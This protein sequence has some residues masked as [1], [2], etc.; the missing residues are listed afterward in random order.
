[1]TRLENSS[2]HPYAG[3]ECGYCGG[4]IRSEDRARDG[5]PAGRSSFEAGAWERNRSSHLRLIGSHQFSCSRSIEN[6]NRTWYIR[7]IYMGLHVYSTYIRMFAWKLC[8]HA[9]VHA[10]GLVDCVLHLRMCVLNE[11]LDRPY[12]HAC[13]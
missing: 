5:V 6:R 8:T 9:H 4:R 12:C 7:S 11:F 1:M 10:K 3:A 13:I 2:V